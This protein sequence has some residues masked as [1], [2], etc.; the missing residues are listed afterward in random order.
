MIGLKITNIYS[1]FIVCREHKLSRSIYTHERP[2]MLCTKRP[3]LSIR[4]NLQSHRTHLCPE[5]TF[6]TQISTKKS[7]KF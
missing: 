6:L 2:Q 5:V 7:P 1:N 3:K 4:C